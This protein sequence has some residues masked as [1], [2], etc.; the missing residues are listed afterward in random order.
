[1][2]AELFLA[3]PTSAAFLPGAVDDAA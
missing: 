1:L 3:A 2:M